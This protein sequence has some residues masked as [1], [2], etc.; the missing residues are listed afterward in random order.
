MSYQDKIREF[1]KMHKKAAECK[2]W[3]TALNRVYY[4]LF[5]RAK[6]FLIDKKFNY[7][8]FLSGYEKHETDPEFSHSTMQAALVLFLNTNYPNVDTKP[9]FQYGK[10]L[11]YRISADYFEDKHTEVSY[12]IALELAKKIIKQLP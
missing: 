1:E 2:C 11:D 12:N 8:R 6:S 10:V 7:R 5:L 3:E 4:H 9:L